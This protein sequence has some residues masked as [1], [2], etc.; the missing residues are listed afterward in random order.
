MTTPL[1]A[2][3]DR[4]REERALLLETLEFAQTILTPGD[5]LHPP[6]MYAYAY[7]KISVVVAKIKRLEAQPRPI[8]HDAEGRN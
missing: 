8:F 2:E 1:T 4:L 5:A 6:W 7:T 3:I